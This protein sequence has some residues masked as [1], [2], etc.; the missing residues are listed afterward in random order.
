MIN[1]QLI[2]SWSKASVVRWATKVVPPLV[3]KEAS[4]SAGQK[5]KPVNGQMNLLAVND[6]LADVCDHSNMY[7][8]APSEPGQAMFVLWS[9][10]TL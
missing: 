4:Y 10:C 6:H 5:T 1:L 8:M 2:F 3:R 9:V 7:K